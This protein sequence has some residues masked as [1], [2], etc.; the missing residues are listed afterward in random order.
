MEIYEAVRYVLWRWGRIFYLRVD[1]GSPFGDPSRQAFSTLHLCL[2]AHGVHLKLNPARS[3]TKNAKVERSQ[4]T[5]ARWSEPQKCENYHHLQVQLDQVVL[6]QREEYPT[7]VCQGKT[8]II[9]YPGLHSNPHPF[10]SKDFDL[11]RVYRLLA[12]GRW[13]RKA[14]DRG[15]VTH[16]GQKYQIKFRNR[17]KRVQV[18]FDPC[19]VEWIFKNQQ[20]QILIR[21]AAKGLSESQIRL[22]NSD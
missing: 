20:N 18:I 14:S 5:T 6:I 3:P 9:A 17:N 1:N 21:L 12:K 11:R 8:R 10:D 7:R 16:F 13:N 15:V 2:V 4:G 19:R 22:T